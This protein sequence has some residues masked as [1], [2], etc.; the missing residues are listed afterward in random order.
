MEHFYKEHNHF[1]CI[2]SWRGFIYGCNSHH[3]TSEL[4]HVYF[5]S[6]SITQVWLYNRVGAYLW[7][8]IYIFIMVFVILNLI[9]AV[10]VDGAPSLIPSSR[11]FCYFRPFVQ[12]HSWSPTFTGYNAVREFRVENSYLEH[13]FFSQLGSCIR[14][15][16]S[17]HRVTLFA[18]MSPRYPLIFHFSAAVTGSGVSDSLASL[19]SQIVLITR[20]VFCARFFE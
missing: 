5:H 14:C 18:S 10:I 20:S 4:L 7:Y 9:I 15:L 6:D 2:F 3:S 16:S 11:F 19:F 8:Y 1:T 17:F 13:P 12:F